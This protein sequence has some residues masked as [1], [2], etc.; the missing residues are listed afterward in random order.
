MRAAAAGVGRTRYDCAVAPAFTHRIEVRFRDCDAMGHVN[1]A[2][3]FTYF[4]Q[5]RAVLAETLGLRRELARTGLG[6]ILAHASC[7][8][9][10]QVVFGD[11][12]DVGMR[13]AAVGRTSFTSEFEVRRVRDE[14]VVAAG[15]SVQAVF[16][17]AAGR[18]A[19]VP[20]GLRAK[21]EA[22]A[23]GASAAP[24]RS[25][26]RGGEGVPAA[27]PGPGDRSS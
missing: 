24:G 16:D 13:V 8:Y 7:D 1:N 22:L 6:V 5:A 21:L 10:A 2:V 23:A 20:D 15:R 26:N 4:E 18:T 11:Q 3:Y 19:P 12:V 25:R 17:Y 27:G 9:K 14:A